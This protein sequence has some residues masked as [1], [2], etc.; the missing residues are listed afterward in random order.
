MYDAITS[1]VYYPNSTRHASLGISSL[2]YSNALCRKT[3]SGLLLHSSYCTFCGIA[4]CT[5][6]LLLGQSL[7][8]CPSPSHSKHFIFLSCAFLHIECT[9]SFHCF[10][11]CGMATLATHSS[12]FLGHSLHWCSLLLYL[13]HC[14]A[15]PPLFFSSCLL[16]STPY[17][18][19]LF[20]STPNLFWGTDV[21]FPSSLLFLQL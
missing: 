10:T 3:Y 17:L 20:D 19:I 9:S 2:Q 21:P 7:H 1:L 16:I 8:W 14:T 5:A 13:K 12:P 11:C 4:I 18:I 15:S 6:F